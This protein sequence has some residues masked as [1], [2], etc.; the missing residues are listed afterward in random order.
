MYFYH[1]TFISIGKTVQVTHIFAFDSIFCFSFCLLFVTL[2]FW[3]CLVAYIT[4][5]LSDLFKLDCTNLIVIGT[6][7]VREKIVRYS[8]YT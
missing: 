8:S 7:F 4:G 6:V 2:T 1:C 3:H 5:K